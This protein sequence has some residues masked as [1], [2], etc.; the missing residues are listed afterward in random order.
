MFTWEKEEGKVEI[1]FPQYDKET[2]LTY[3]VT[4]CEV[5]QFELCLEI[6]SQGND[7][8]NKTLYSRHEWVIGSTSGIENTLEKYNLK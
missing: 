6:T 8:K 1:F 4:S 3:K 7:F 2:Q 5:A